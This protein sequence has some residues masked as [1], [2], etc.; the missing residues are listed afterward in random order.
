MILLFMNKVQKS[1]NKKY[2]IC[3]IN[4]PVIYPKGTRGTD[5][6]QPLGIAY[7]AAVLREKNF[8]VAIIDAAG[9]GWQNMKEF[10]ERRNYNGLDYE[11]IAKRIKNLKPK[12]VGITITF[13]VQKDSA[14]RVAEI[15]KKTDKHIKVVV[16]GPHVT[17]QAK[18]C[19][20]NSNIDYAVVGEGE[21]TVVELM[22]A[23]L[24]NTT[25][26]KLSLIKGIA[27]KQKKEIIITP[28]RPFIVDL[29]RIPF[30]ARDLLPMGE[31]FKAARSR[32]ANRDLDK[33]WASLFT[34]RGCPFNCVF[35]SIH[36]SMGRKWRA[37]SPENIL[38]ELKLLVQKYDV[39]QIDFED[40]NISWDKNRMERLCEMI[41]ENKLKFEWF[42]P[43]GIRADTLDEPLLKKMKK[44]GCR[45]LWFAPE[46]GSQ[47]VVNEIIGK[48]I[49]L[50]Y[51]EKMV[52][53]C[54]RIGISSNC[55]FVIGLPGETKKDIQKTFSFAKKLGRL[56]ADNCIFFLATPLYGTRLY[57]EAESKGY[58]IREGDS[59]QRYDRPHIQTPEFSGEELILMRETA[60]AENRKLYIINSLRKLYY[61]LT[62]NPSLVVGQLKNI[63]RIGV[64]FISRRINQVKKKI[65]GK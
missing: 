10:D 51:I 56:G 18:E 60:L 42:A 21:D 7:V 43:N 33:P 27:Y 40:D 8:Q 36:L 32:R 1:G 55:F 38:A 54:K 2:L 35:C 23:V 58:L 29:D 11:E 52:D 62:N 13:T 44:S 34:S 63:S 45:E 17:V 15:V 14:F 47:R 41:I 64:I 24:K 25:V 4:P 46:S 26:K 49:D 37:R 50:K 31:Y 19:L 12:V 39:R 3:L 22:E 16:G 59:L 65:F 5:I 48:N 53:A 9:L 6:F 30:P 20:S 61:Y 57:K 28:P